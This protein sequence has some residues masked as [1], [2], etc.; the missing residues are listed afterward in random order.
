M[1]S[2]ETQNY[3]KSETEEKDKQ[4]KTRLN[5]C[6]LQLSLRFWSH[7]TCIT[8]RKVNFDYYVMIS[9]RVEKLLK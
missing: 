2:K 8:Q 7:Y 4:P 3:F 6:Q 5:Y 1:A 9:W